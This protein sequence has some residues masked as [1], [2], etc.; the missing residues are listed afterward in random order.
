M[1]KLPKRLVR[2][3]N[4]M[5]TPAPLPP[6]LGRT[7]GEVFVR[8][9]QEPEIRRISLGGGWVAIEAERDAAGMTD[10][11]PSR[12]IGLPTQFGQTRGDIHIEVGIAVEHTPDPGEIFR[13][14]SH[15][16]ADEYGARVLR[17]QALELLDQRLKRRELRTKEMPVR[18]RLK[19]LPA[20]V[21]VIKRLEEGNRVGDMDQHG[22]GRL[23][24]GLPQVKEPWII[25]WN[26]FTC[27]VPVMQ[28]QRLPYFK[29]ARPATHAVLQ[30]A[31][32]GLPEIRF[33]DQIPIAVR[34]GEEAARI[35]AVIAIQIGLQFIAPHTVQVDDAGKVA[36]FHHAEQRRHI[37]YTPLLICSE[38][39]AQ[40]IMY[41]DGREAGAGDMV[42]RP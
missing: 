1:V 27:S 25:D 15:M 36:V 4:A 21:G 3:V 31:G 35:G 11:E 20:F 34:E 10:E 26:Q 16:G 32:H 41:I 13:V 18:M 9:L 14:T 5:D 2:Q 42:L 23:A 40:V 22:D 29:A 6:R 8:R 37:L 24:G 17:D 30:L 39:A 19:L 38:P 28:A 33:G 7:I 12:R